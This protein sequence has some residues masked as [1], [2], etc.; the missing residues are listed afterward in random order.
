MLI[1]A[2]GVACEMKYSADPKRSAIRFCEMNL[3]AEHHMQ[4]LADL[5]AERGFCERHRKECALDLKPGGINAVD[6]EIIGFPC[7]PYSRMR[8]KRNHQGSAAAGP[9]SACHFQRNLTLE[10]AAPL[11]AWRSFLGSAA[12]HQMQTMLSPLHG[13]DSS[14]SCACE[15]QCA[16]LLEHWWMTP[17]PLPPVLF[18]TACAP[19]DGRIRTVG[20]SAFRGLGPVLVLVAA[21]GSK[22]FAGVEISGWRLVVNS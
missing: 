15:A 7:A 17:S 21:L 13:A 20:V 11:C 9:S 2:M 6:V 19:C 10:S 8:A 18:C 1:Q 14:N 5:T 22:V 16:L 12:R 4:T 3:C